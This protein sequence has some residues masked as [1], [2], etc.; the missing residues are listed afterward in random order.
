MRP[1]QVRLILIL[2][3][4]RYYFFHLIIIPWNLINLLLTHFFLELKTGNPLELVNSMEVS[5]HQASV[6]SCLHNNS[7]PSTSNYQSHEV[8]YPEMGGWNTILEQD[9]E[10]VNPVNYSCQVVQHE[11]TTNT[12]TSCNCDECIVGTL[13]TNFIP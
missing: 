2:Q 12:T 9:L 11:S 13:I 4:L 5:L 1:L 3:S 10:F 7:Y 8:M 6:S